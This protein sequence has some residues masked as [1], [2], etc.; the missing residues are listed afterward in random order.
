MRR[1]LLPLADGDLAT[2]LDE[3]AREGRV[4]QKTLYIHYGRTAALFAAIVERLRESVV[5]Q[6]GLSRYTHAAIVLFSPRCAV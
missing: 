2:S 5:F 3:I 6:Q 1:L 4:A